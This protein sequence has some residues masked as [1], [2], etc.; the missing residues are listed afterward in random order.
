MTLRMGLFMY[1]VVDA[2]VI[3]RIF[4]TEKIPLIPSWRLNYGGAYVRA[5]VAVVHFFWRL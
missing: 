1:T 4:R 3:W 2:N 5:T